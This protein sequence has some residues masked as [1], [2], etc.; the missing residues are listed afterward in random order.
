MPEEP[1]GRNQAKKKHTV[2]PR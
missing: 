1:K 2:P